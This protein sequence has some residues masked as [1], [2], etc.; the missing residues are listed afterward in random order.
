MVLQ[1][2]LLQLGSDISSRFDAV[3]HQLH[4]QSSRLGALETLLGSVLRQL[5]DSDTLGGGSQATGEGEA[6]KQKSDA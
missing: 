4:K 1:R 6:A 2:L 3:Q 5:K